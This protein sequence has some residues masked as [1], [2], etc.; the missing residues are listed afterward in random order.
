MKIAGD[1][2]W[3]RTLITVA[4]SF[5]LVISVWPPILVEANKE[6]E[7]KNNL[8]DVEEDQKKTKNEIE[9]LKKKVDSLKE[10]LRKLE[11]DLEKEK[12]E[13]EKAEKKLK[14]AEETLDQQADR[15]KTS[16]R[17]MYLNGGT[18][19][20]AS[21]L[22]AESF[23]E[24]LARFEMMRLI[25]KK[26][27]KVVEKYYQA[28]SKAEK[29]KKEVEKSRKEVEEKTEE[30]EKE[31]KKMVDLLKENRSTLHQLEEKEQDYRQTLSQLNLEHLKAGNFPYQGP[32]QR[33]VNGPV[34]SGYGP[35]GGEFHTGVD[36]D[37]TTSTPIR[38]AA[39]GRVIRAQSCSCGYGYY[40]MID[41][42]GGV[43]SLY[44]HMWSWQSK[45][46]VGQVVKKGQLIAYVG[47]NG[48]STG[49][50]LHFEVHKGRP[51]NYTNP[52][53]YMQ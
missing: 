10:D 36:F 52:W 23:D 6:D 41:H 12:K 42:G 37:G 22:A 34:T 11:K 4:V 50:H 27:Y 43:F 26:D 46:S 18:N 45:V 2:G 49:S 28:K 53:S 24:F 29:A 32:L 19:Q 30:A 31:Y 21:L 48:R 9:K 8:K 5:G 39:N 25:I 35:R 14:K 47:N 44:A 20:M 7:V 40:I 17:S 33:P 1:G 38:A 51:G 13:E 15:Y 16:V 3:K